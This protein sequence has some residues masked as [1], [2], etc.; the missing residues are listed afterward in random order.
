MNASERNKV[1]QLRQRVKV[2]R[3][4]IKVLDLKVTRLEYKIDQ[5]VE[6]YRLKLDIHPE[7][8][9]KLEE[10]TKTLKDNIVFVCDSDSEEE[11]DDEDW[12]P[13]QINTSKERRLMILLRRSRILTTYYDS[14]EAQVEGLEKATDYLVRSRGPDRKDRIYSLDEEVEELKDKLHFLLTSDDEW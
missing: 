5:Q 1:Q 12:A 9:A 7:D 6:R 14:L 11:E 13:P 10:E 2:L 4:C 3:R 8:L